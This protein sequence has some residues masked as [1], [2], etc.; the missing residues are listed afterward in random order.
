M[1]LM[2][3]RESWLGQATTANRSGIQFWKI[4]RRF[5]SH[6]YVPPEPGPWVPLRLLDEI[7]T[8]APDWLRKESF[9]S[10]IKSFGMAFPN[11]TES[12]HCNLAI[13]SPVG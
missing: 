12:A 1:G 3:H 13:V 11:P 4:T 10:T 2:F 7:P 5:P 9:D 6:H 8:N